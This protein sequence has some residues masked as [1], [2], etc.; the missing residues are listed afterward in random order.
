MTT[1]PRF[2]ELLALLA[3]AFFLPGCP[4]VDDSWDCADPASW[5]AGPAADALVSSVAVAGGAHIDVDET[6][7]YAGDIPSGGD[8]WPVWA[9]WGEFDRLE[10]GYWTHNLEH[11]GI[12]LLYHPCVAAEVVDDLREYALGVPDDDGGAFR[13]IL[14]P[15]PGLPSAVAAVSWGWNLQDD[16]VDP[17]AL[18][19]FVADHYRDGPEDVAGNGAMDDGWLGREAGDFP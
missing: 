13:W 2:S 4:T 16:A 3:C 18:D 11:G 1:I 8:H 19:A 10:Y 15:F 14:T 6:P 12:V 17:V 9:K 5:S 7:T